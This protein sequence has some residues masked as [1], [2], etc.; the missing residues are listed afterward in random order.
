MVI[1]HNAPDY[2]V[3][4]LEVAQSGKTLHRSCGD[5]CE[6]RTYY[7]ARVARLEKSVEVSPSSSRGTW[8]IWQK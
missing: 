7:T 3:M 4:N 5:W 2:P 8:N 6:A 1:S